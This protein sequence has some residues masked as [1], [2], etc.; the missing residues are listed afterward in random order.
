VREL[1]AGP[2]FHRARGRRRKG[3]SPCDLCPRR[4]RSA[5]KSSEAARSVLLQAAS[6]GAERRVDPRI[7]SARLCD[8]SPLSSRAD[9]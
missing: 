5:D 9:V 8:R 6:E 2:G 3:E 7:F 1:I 4:A